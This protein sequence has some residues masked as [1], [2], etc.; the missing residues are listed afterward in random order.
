MKM[1]RSGIASVVC[2]S[3]LV[4]AMP[5]AAAQAAPMTKTAISKADGGLTLVH[6]RGRG[7]RGWGAGALIGGIIAG[8]L[9]AAAVSEGRAD[10]RDMRRCAR[11][12]PDF[13][14]RTGTYINRYGQE[15]VC[16]YLR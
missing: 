12:F 14:Y 6:G 16:P 15:R 2:A 5:L 7:G 10:D 1:V 4:S 13:S 9:I 11:D 3:L 8:G